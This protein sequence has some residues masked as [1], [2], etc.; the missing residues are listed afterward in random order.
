MNRI[1]S[2]FN[3]ERITNVDSDLSF[4][5]GNTPKVESQSKADNSYDIRDEVNDN[6]SRNTEEPNEEEKKRRE[7]K[8]DE[9]TS[10]K[11][12]KD[13]NNTNNSS[14]SGSGAGSSA[15]AASSTGAAVAST[16]AAVAAA[17]LVS[18]ATLS[19]LVGIDVYGDNKEIHSFLSS[20]AQLHSCAF[21]LYHY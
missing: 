12:N 19:N 20:K 6:P 21:L 16:A 5:F 3:Q 8:K 9:D 11:D 18:V 17:A 7:D 1:D 13:L 15:S 4:E 14:S 10:S 2:E